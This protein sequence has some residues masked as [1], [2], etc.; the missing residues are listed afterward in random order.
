M[1]AFIYTGKQSM[2]EGDMTQAKPTADVY[3]LCTGT[4]LATILL[5]KTRRHRLSFKTQE[6]KRAREPLFQLGA[7]M[8]EGSQEAAQVTLPPLVATRRSS[9]R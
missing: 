6:K 3:L 5:I 9:G 4:H 2:G 8:T 7:W 1:G